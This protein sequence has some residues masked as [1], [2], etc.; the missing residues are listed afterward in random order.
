[1]TITSM[2]NAAAG[3]LARSHLQ[4]QSVLDRVR[5]IS[6]PRY[7]PALLVL[8]A[9]LVFSATAFADA[10]GAFTGGY[11]A[12]TMLNNICTFILG[13]FGQTLAVLGIIGIGM[14]WMFGRVSLGLVA[15]VIGGIIIMFAAGYI[16][17]TLTGGAAGG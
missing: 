1:M 6:V 8:V 13:A 11:Q 10:G 14:S 2:R 15:G 7:A 9:T 16:G 17:S 4:G 12:Q 3:L 5:L